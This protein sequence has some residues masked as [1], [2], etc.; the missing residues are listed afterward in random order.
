MKE[1]KLNLRQPLSRALISASGWSLIDPE[2]KKH[3]RE[4]LNVLELGSL[5]EV[6]EDLV[7]ISVKANFRSLGSRYGAD[8]QK[9]ASA[10]SATDTLLLVRTLRESGNYQ[11][12]YD[13]KKADLI[14]ED[15][16]ITETPKEGW[17][18][19]TYGGETVALDLTLTPELLKLGITREAI[20]II[21]NLRKTS[22][23]KLSDRINIRW[24][25]CPEVAST[26]L[27][28]SKEISEEVLALSL[29][30]DLTLPLPEGN[31]GLTFLIEK[32]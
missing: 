30:Q 3:I 17:A 29:V 28:Y 23:F 14:L 18:F 1:F 13:D 9:I 7:D 19:A 16:I 4:E 22:G 2:L 27:Q 5:S 12:T 8:V 20:H 32:A 25:A 24:N 26:I 10:I 6:G 15:L 31:L 11:L 21:Q